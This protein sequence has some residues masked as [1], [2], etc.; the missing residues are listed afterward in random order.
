MKP[1]TQSPEALVREST[2]ARFTNGTG[3]IRKRAMMGWQI[4]TREM[5]RQTKGG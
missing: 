2:A 5:A 3:G 4:S 1:K